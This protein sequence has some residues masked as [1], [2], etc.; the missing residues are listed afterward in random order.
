MNR[1]ADHAALEAI[2]SAAFAD[3]YCA[4]PETIRTS[5]HIDVADIAGATCLRCARL[6]PAAIFRRACGLGVEVPA[7]E[8][9]VAEEMYLRQNY[10][11]PA[12]S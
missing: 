6:H 4:A 9:D 8:A 3:L 10:M 5:M 7:R 1:A 2:E 11:S 12:R